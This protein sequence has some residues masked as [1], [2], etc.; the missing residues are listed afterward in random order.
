[1]GM[2]EQH[3]VS[4]QELHIIRIRR[5]DNGWF[6]LQVIKIELIKEASSSESIPHCNSSVE[7]AEWDLLLLTN[8]I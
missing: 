8:G 2:M 1:M 3:I 4:E 6:L 5:I 7:K